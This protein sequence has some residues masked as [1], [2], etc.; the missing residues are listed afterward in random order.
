VITYSPARY[1]TEGLYG[2]KSLGLY[3]VNTLRNVAM[4][5]CRTSYGLTL[6]IDF[7]PNQNAHKYLRYNKPII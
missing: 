6:D 7:V 1:G 4:Q 5:K 3:P 2:F